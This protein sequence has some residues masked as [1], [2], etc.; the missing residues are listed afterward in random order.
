MYQKYRHHQIVG[1]EGSHKTN[2]KIL[3]RFPNNGND[4]KMAEVFISKGVFYDVGELFLRNLFR[5]LDLLS[6]D[7]N[8]GNKNKNIGDENDDC[9]K[10]KAAHAVAAGLDCPVVIG[11]LKEGTYQCLS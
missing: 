10:E 9:K 6:L 8:Q 1:L 3:C 11:A 4:D 2:G 7:Q 5:I